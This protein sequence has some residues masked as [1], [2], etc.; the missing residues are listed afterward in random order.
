VINPQ[1]N[2]CCKHDCIFPNFSL[3]PCFNFHFNA[4][5]IYRFALL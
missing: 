1:T 2:Q 3:L 4:S 5:L